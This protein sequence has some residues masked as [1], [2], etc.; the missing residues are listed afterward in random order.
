[1]EMLIVKLSPCLNWHTNLFSFVDVFYFLNILFA[2]HRG[3]ECVAAC[4]LG[5]RVRIPP[6]AGMSLVIVVCC[7]ITVSATRRSLVQRSPTECSVCVCVC[8]CVC[9]Y[10]SLN[11]FTFS[12]LK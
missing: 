12:L 9:V 10:V 2:D 11:V 4:L 6:E 8:V 7:Q 1:M 3:R 5:L